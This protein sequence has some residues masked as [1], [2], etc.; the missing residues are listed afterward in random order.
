M[1]CFIWPRRLSPL[2]ADLLSDVVN[3]GVSGLALEALDIVVVVRLIFILVNS[4]AKL[5]PESLSKILP[6]LGLRFRS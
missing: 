6:R 4:E 2:L 3:L 5:L 1:L